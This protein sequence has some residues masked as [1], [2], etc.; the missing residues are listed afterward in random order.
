MVSSPVQRAWRQIEWALYQA[1]PSL[2]AQL[3]AGVS[4]AATDAAESVLGRHLPVGMK[5]FFQIHD[6]S[7]SPSL[8]I[9]IEW[10]GTDPGA[11]WSVSS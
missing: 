8:R 1:D 11:G 6:G 7:S 10:D 9:E 4:K 3:P 5:E 2:V